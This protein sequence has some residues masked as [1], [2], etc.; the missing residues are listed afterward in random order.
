MIIGHE[1]NNTALGR[2][3]NILSLC[4][5]PL[6]LPLWSIMPFFFFFFFL[7]PPLLPEVY[8]GSQATGPEL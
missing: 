3:W 1:K 4:G 5:W 8:G 2:E 6:D 7:A